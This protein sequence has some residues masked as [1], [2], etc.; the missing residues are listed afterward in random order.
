MSPT[1][2]LGG[3]AHLP[4]T[5]ALIGALATSWPTSSAAQLQFNRTDY[6]VGSGPR[7]GA[8]ADLNGDGHPD[9]V[10]ADQGSSHV[11][12]WFGDGNGGFA[13]R[14]DVPAGIGAV[15]VAAADLDGDGSTDLVVANINAS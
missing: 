8:I 15:Y 9:F 4:L 6:T 3:L 12:I 11:T 5:A 7:W 2:R 13:G 1:T 10:V 14:T